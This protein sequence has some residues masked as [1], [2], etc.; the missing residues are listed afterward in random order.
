M[1]DS[2]KVAFFNGTGFVKITD[3]SE[4]DHSPPW[5]SNLRPTHQRL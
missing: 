2:K 5:N 4:I 1:L 3:S